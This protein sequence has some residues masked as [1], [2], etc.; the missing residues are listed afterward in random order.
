MGLWASLQPIPCNLLYYSIFFYIMA[1]ARIVTFRAASETV[2]EL[3]SLAQAMDRDRT[4]LLNEAVQ[5]YLARERRFRAMV[6][7][8]L[9]ASERGDLV[10]DEQVDAKIDSWLHDARTRERSSTRK[11]S[12]GRK[13]RARA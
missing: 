12:Q 1:P 5:S 4:Y 3:D 8:G 13:V 2:D 11:S 9:H 10:D 7:E 6:E